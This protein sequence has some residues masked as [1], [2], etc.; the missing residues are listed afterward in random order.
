MNERIEIPR[1]IQRCI[2]RIE[3]EYQRSEAKEKYKLR[4]VWKMPYKVRIELIGKN[5]IKQRDIEPHQNAFVYEAM[6]P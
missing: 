1:E 5:I 3:K 4:A 2:K 6:N